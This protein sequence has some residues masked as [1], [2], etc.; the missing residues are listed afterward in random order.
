[1]TRSALILALL[2]LFVQAPASARADAESFATLLAGDWK[3]P[4]QSDCRLIRLRIKATTRAYTVDVVG[5]D[6]TP[7]QTDEAFEILSVDDLS[8]RVWNPVMGQEQLVVIDGS[9]SH[10][11]SAP[12]GEGRQVYERC[13]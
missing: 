7:I 4:S 13:P 3:E 12:N 10:V 2:A 8:A 6:G 9:E 5:L 11:V 1:M